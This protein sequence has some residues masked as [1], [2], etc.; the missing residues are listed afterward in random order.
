MT[1]VTENAMGTIVPV[2]DLVI[3]TLTQVATEQGKT[4]APLFDNIALMDCGLDSLCIAIAVARLD[5]QLGVDPFG[6]SDDIS[7]P[8]TIGDFIRIYEN[9]SE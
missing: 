8:V 7:L 5:D 4:L 1:P 3:A 2:R 6:G 9:A